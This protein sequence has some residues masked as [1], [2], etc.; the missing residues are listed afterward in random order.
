MRLGSTSTLATGLL[1]QVIKRFL[2]Q[3]P[4]TFVGLQTLPTPQLAELLNQNL[5][6]LAVTTG[7]VDPSIFETRIL[8]TT[9]AVCIVPQNHPLACSDWVDLEE[10]RRH[11]MILLND[12]DNI[13]IRMRELLNGLG[14]PENIVVETNSSI[15]I[16]ALVVAGV[17][18]GIVNPYIANTMSQGLVIKELRPSIRVDVSLVRSMT[19]A[20]SLLGEAFSRLLADTIA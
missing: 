14:A 10:L 18:V 17:G 7:D 12:S 13:V 19:L 6:D 16:C 4:G 3:F 11:Q 20:P 2:A 8:T 5:I 9:S 1:P 15:T